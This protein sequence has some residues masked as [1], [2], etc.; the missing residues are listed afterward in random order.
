MGA[1]V[2]GYELALLQTADDLGGVPGL[3]GAAGT[4][5]RVRR[6]PAG[7]DDGR[8]AR[9]TRPLAARCG[10]AVSA[11]CAASPCRPWGPTIKIEVQGQIRYPDAFVS[12]TPGRPRATRSS[13][14]LSSSSRCSARAR[15]VP[16]GS[17]SCGNI[18]RR[19]RFSA[20]SS[21]SRTASPPWCLPATATI[22]SARAL[23]EADVLQMP[24]IGIELALAEIYADA[25]LGEA[26]EQP[27][28]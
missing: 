25:D 4:A 15:R 16:T 14:N 3:G 24:E 20:T 11:V 12:C 21:W 26:A 13:L 9:G 2:A 5:L 23:T 22:G 1:K 6:V 10:P 18:R 27:A 17:K 8:N 7:R 19:P 28:A